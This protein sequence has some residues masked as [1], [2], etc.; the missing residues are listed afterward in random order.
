[1]AKSSSSAKLS[2]SDPAA[3][4]SIEPTASAAALGGPVGQM[5]RELD[6]RMAFQPAR[7]PY[8]DMPED[9]FHAISVMGGYVGLAAAFAGSGALIWWLACLLG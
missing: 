5:L 3:S 2:H 7:M 8:A 4:R 9:I 1:M 6:E